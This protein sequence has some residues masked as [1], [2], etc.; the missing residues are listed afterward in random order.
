MPVPED[1]P[2]RG[3]CLAR[4]HPPLPSPPFVVGDGFPVRDDCWH[5]YRNLITFGSNIFEE[6][7]YVIL[8]GRKVR[9]NYSWAHG[10]ISA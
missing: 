8:D 5:P 3:I 7:C 4:H 10:S 6:L 9:L 2:V 1:A